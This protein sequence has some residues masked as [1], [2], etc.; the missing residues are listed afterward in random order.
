MSSEVN[1]VSESGNNFEIKCGL[2]IAIFA[3][4]MS[5]TDLFSGKYGDDQM[6]AI[7]EKSAAYMWYQAKSIRSSIVEG[8]RELIVSLQ[9]ADLFQR[10]PASEAVNSHLDNLEKKVV[11]YE[12]QKNEILLGSKNVDQK[13][14]AQDVD[15]KMGQV[16]G[17][18]ELEKQIEIYDKAGNNFNLA[19]LFFQLCLV[20]G[21]IALVTKRDALRNRFFY[22]M[23]S[24]G[25]LGVSFSVFAFTVIQ[26]LG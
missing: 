6:R 18:K 25:G 16:V 26:Q 11:K 24:L 1:E 5:I 17:A 15:N 23:I 3:A 7:N 2:V 4:L 12:K 13:E 19:N 8:Q 20:T 21:A 14:W 9:K 22:A 10:G